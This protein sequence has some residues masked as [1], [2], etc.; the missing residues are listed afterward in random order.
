MYPPWNADRHFTKQYYGWLEDIS[1]YEGENR[2]IANHARIATII[3][4]LKGPMNQHLMLKVTNTTTLDEVHG[5][6]SNYF[7]N[8]YIGVDEDNTVGGLHDQPKQP[9]NNPY[10]HWNTN[11]WKPWKSRGKRKGG[12][13]KKCQC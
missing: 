2:A 8:I 10:N 13:Q 5:W 11:R 1:R 6:N 4:H 3:D 9:P 7:N 12:K